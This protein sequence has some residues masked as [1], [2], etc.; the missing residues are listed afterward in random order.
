[1]SWAGKNPH[2]CYLHRL[3]LVWKATFAP[4]NGKDDGKLDTQLTA[5]KP[6]PGK[7]GVGTPVPSSSLDTRGSREGPP[8]ARSSSCSRCCRLFKRGGILSDSVVTATSARYKL[9]IYFPS[10]VWQWPRI[11]VTPISHILHT[12]YYMAHT[13]ATPP[14]LLSVPRITT[15]IASSL[16]ALCSGTNYVRW[17]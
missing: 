2:P 9:I 3:L 16:V 15:L 1:M 5:A 13:T 11:N 7:Y 6:V 4:I 17:K 12:T 10:L 14:G 8:R